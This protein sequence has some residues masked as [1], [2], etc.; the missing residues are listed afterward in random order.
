MFIIVS[1][2]IPDDRRRDRVMKALKD[3]GA[4]VQYSLF[5]C[6]LKPEVY[7][8]LR[9]RLAKLVDK[10]EDNIRFYMLCQEDVKKRKVWGVERVE[11]GVRPMYLVGGTDREKR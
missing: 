7:T 2:D 3:F 10:K 11:V 5:E 8:R 1:Y 9:E 4:H 6:D